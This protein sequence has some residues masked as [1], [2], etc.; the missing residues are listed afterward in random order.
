MKFNPKFW[1]RF[2]VFNFLIVAF[3]GVLMR[4]KIAFSFPFFE[5]KHLQHAHSHFA[6]DGWITQTLFVLMIAYLQAQSGIFNFRKYQFLLV[7]NLVA[8]YGMLVTFIIQG[9]GVY[10]ITFATFSIVVS[11]SFAFVFY[12]DLLAINNNSA[13]KWFGAAL[14]FNIL[15]AIGTAYLSYLMANHIADQN[16]FLASLYFYL[17]FQYNG[18]FFFASMGLIIN[19]LQHNLPQFKENRSIFLLFFLSCIPAYFLS[20]LWAKIPAWLYSLTVLAAILQVVAWVLFVVLVAKHWHYIK[21]K[22]G[23]L[24]RLSLQLV[25]LACSIKLLLQ[26]GSTI[27]FL[28]KLA[29]GFRPIVIAYLHLILLAVFSLFL[30][31]FSYIMNYL[32]TG[33]QVSKAIYVLI[34]GIFLNEFVLMV[35]GVAGFMYFPVPYVNEMLL[36]IAVFIFLGILMLL[37]AKR[38]NKI[39]T[40][41]PQDD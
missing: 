13:K 1:L 26:L 25:A 39:V 23:F 30:I 10:S 6:F 14:L 37:T 11:F 35:Q 34:A 32:G 18:W 19:W 40:N 3:L 9:Y 7:A 24:A 22:T 4:Y 41:M 31:G 17:H 36:L 28:G 38:E 33:K 15:S 29:F 2:S 27:P 8:A 5:Q 16:K 20:T 21:L 12:K